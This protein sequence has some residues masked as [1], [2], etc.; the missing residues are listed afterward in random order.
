VTGIN[1]RYAVVNLPM[2]IICGSRSTLPSAAKSAMSSRSHY[3][4]VVT[5]KSIVAAM[6]Q[7]GEHGI[8]PTAAARVLWLK[9]HPLRAVVETATAIDLVEAR[10]DVP[11]EKRSKVSE[12]KPIPAG[13][14]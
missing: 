4:G 9:T 10:S 2:P 3:A 14:A 5:A 6:R 12:T 11:G 13:G 7:H 8:E 1:I